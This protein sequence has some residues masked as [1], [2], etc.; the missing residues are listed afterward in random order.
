MLSPGFCKKKFIKFF[1]KNK[2][3]FL[4]VF[5]LF[6]KKTLFLIYAFL[7]YNFILFPYF[8]FLIFLFAI[9]R[10][11]IKKAIAQIAANT[12]RQKKTRPEGRAKQM[13]VFYQPVKA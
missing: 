11:K 5:P 6:Y 3:I 12:K 1:K 13:S 8:L 7:I 2:K 10:K 4:K 9:Q